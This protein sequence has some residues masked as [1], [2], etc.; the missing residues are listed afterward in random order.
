[1]NEL[2]ALKIENK[3]LKQELAEYM[4]LLEI[5]RKEY[6]RLFIAEQIK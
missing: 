4:L 1:M 2:D 3:E 5:I 6:A